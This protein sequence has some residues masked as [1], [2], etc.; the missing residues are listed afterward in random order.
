M[1]TFFPELLAALLKF[2]LRS[3]SVWDRRMQTEGQTLAFAEILAIFH[4]MT[5]LQTRESFTRKIPL[6][7]WTSIHRISQ[8]THVKKYDVE[9]LWESARRKIITPVC[10]EF[11]FFWLCLL[12]LSG[13]QFGEIFFFSRFFSWAAAPSLSP[14]P[15]CCISQSLFLWRALCSLPTVDW[16]L[17]QT[18]KCC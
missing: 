15:S 17:A 12:F 16:A 1:P 4:H 9:I 10:I 2:N 7:I 3:W 5:S 18:Q 8:S 11:P 13:A 14:P 6:I